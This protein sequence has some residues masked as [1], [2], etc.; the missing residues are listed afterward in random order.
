MTYK[1]PITTK[2]PEE[3]SIEYMAPKEALDEAEGFFSFTFYIR[4]TWSEGKDNYLYLKGMDYY[5]KILS[6]PPFSTWKLIIFTD[7]YTYREIQE[8]KSLNLETIKD[9]MERRSVELMKEYFIL[10]TE[11][12][13]VIFAVVNWPRHQRRKEIPQINGG[14]LR[15]FRS[16]LPFDFPTKYVF[17]RDADTFFEGSLKE[18]GY[19]GLYRT[20]EG[21]YNKE[22]HNKVK[23]EFG[24]FLY[25]WETH[26]YNLLPS[27]QE[28]VKQK[29]L[30]IVGSGRAGFHTNK[31][32]RDWHSN[33]LLGKDAPFGVFAG[34]VNIT[35][36][37]PV[38]QTYS[39][40]DDFI[41]YVDARSVRNNNHPKSKLNLE[42][43]ARRMY[44]NG[45]PKSTPINKENLITYRKTK[46]DKFLNKMKGEEYVLGMEKELYYNF[47]NN[48][49]INRIGRD[50]QLYLFTL[51]P[52]A[53]DNLFIF[54]IDLDDKDFPKVNFDYDDMMKSE[55]KAALNTGFQKS[56][57]GTR[58]KKRTQ[59][60]TRKA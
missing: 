52:R 58:K 3:G 24:E 29:G 31:Y 23:R 5:R 19:G 55:Y 27:I 44:R 54:R 11:D 57:G 34:F 15:P 46:V 33:E 35:P 20:P 1:V 10:L 49:S 43:L 51:M 36:G 41:E 39:A 25:K 8:I 17:I 28:R 21:E 30:L 37:V 4:A 47:S 48:N 7:V 40:W 60:K 22:G 2:N 53:F 12:P 32:K 14:A 26:F 42:Y 45:T 59:R 16:R 18:L 38:F 6:D 56:K 9:Q 50:E 13:K